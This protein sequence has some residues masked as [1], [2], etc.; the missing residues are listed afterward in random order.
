[1]AWTQN[2]RTDEKVER[3]LGFEAT[4]L[5]SLSGIVR[6]HCADGDQAKVDHSIQLS[7][8]QAR[9]LADEL[10]KLALASEASVFDTL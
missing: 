10:M 7:P 4:P 1:M 8:S 9:A 5:S 2:R 3:L 6:L